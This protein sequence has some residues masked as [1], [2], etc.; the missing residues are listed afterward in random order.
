MV[1]MFELR[2][3]QAF[4]TDDRGKSSVQIMVAVEGCGIVEADGMQPVTLA[5]GDAV[6]VPASVESFRVRPQWTVE[7]L[8]ACVPGEKL[9]EPATR[10]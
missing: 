3:P 5:K 1:D 8:K 2:E 6:V 10:M 7:F 9:G 4:R